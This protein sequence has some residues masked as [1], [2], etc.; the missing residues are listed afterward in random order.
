MNFEEHHIKLVLTELQNRF[1][2]PV[3]E[4]KEKLDNYKMRDKT[5]HVGRFFHFG[6]HTIN[7][8]LNDILCRPSGFPTFN[9]LCDY[10]LKK[11]GKDD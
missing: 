6:N 3:K 5:D 4:W 8:I 1:G 7:P 9:K 11:G 2:F 10:V